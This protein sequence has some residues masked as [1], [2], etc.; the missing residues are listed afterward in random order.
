MSATHSSTP[1]HK[2][3]HHQL[4]T[5]PTHHPHTTISI[6]PVQPTP[7]YS[8]LI[9]PTPEK[10]IIM[11]G[12]QPWTSIHVQLEN[13]LVAVHT[14]YQDQVLVATLPYPNQIT[15]E[16]YITC[17]LYSVFSV[18]IL[19]AYSVYCIYPCFIYV[20]FHICIVSL[21]QNAHYTI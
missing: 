1:S 8:S 21:L 17:R 16:Y 13:I 10:Y 11:P 14:M 3:H 15:V 12:C 6:A 5:K 18:M 7:P 9:V 19:T 4:V 2:Q 20:D